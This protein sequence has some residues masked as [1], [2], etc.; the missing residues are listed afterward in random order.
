MFWNGPPTMPPPMAMWA[1][2][3]LPSRP[4]LTMAI[5]LRNN[6]SCSLRCCVPTWNT[7]PV[8]FTAS[9]MRKPSSIVSVSGFSQYTSQP[10]RS[11]AMAIGTCQW[12]GVPMVTISRLFLFEQLAIVAVQLELLVE[13]GVELVRVDVVDVAHGD[14]SACWLARMAIALPW[15]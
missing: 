14:H 3:F 7:L 13:L 1:L 12:S 4:L 9:R 6:S 10:A 8:S 11:A 5:A 15:A 2:T